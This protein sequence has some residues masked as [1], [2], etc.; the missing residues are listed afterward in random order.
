MKYAE[1]SPREC[2]DGSIR[3]YYGDTFQL[4]FEMEFTNENDEPI[5]IQ[6]TDVIEVCF[7]DKHDTPIQ[8]FTAIG[9]PSITMD[10]TEDISRKFKVGEYTYCTRFKGEYIK[11]LMRKNKVVVE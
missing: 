1:Q 3:W 7:R 9:T 4:T 2:K 6:P 8:K 5:E 10:F 11:T